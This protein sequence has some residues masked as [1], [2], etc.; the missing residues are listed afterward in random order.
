MIGMVISAVLI[1]ITSLTLFLR[2]DMSQILRIINFCIIG[3]FTLLLVRSLMN[4]DTVI[5]DEIG[6]RSRVNGMG[7]VKWSYVEDF[8][9]VKLRNSMGILFHINNHEALLNEMNSMSRGMMR[10]NIKKLGSPVIIPQPEL[11]KPLEIVLQELL[12]Y[13]AKQIVVN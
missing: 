13:K 9:I 5:V 1:I 10:T 4:T 8:E 7:L 12:E 2:E 6:I 11:H 3:I